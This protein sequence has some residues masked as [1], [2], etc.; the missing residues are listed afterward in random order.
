MPTPS[1]ICTCSPHGTF[2]GRTLHIMTEVGPCASACHFDA[3]A[4]V[5]SPCQKNRQDTCQTSRQAKC[6]NKCKKG[7]QNTFGNISPSIGIVPRSLCKS[8][9]SVAHGCTFFPQQRTKST[10]NNL[11]TG[12]EHPGLLKDPYFQHPT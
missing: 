10:N 7:N 4:H 8:K 6:Q 2:D 12:T 9:Y 3:R 11:L 1:Q 5:M